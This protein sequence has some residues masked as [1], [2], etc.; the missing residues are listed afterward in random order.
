MVAWPTI[1]AEDEKNHVGEMVISLDGKVLAFGKDTMDAIN[2]AK[3]V[4]PN[5]DQKDFLIS[6]IYP[7]YIAA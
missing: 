3:K 4:V 5:L 7:E 2:K 6:R 1:S